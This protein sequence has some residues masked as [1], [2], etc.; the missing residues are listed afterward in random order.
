VDEA[1]AEGLQRVS[2]Q[3]SVLSNQMQR[4]GETIHARMLLLEGRVR[5]IENRLRAGGGAEAGSWR[6]SE[7]RPQT[8]A[9]GARPGA[10]PVDP[11]R[12]TTSRAVA[13]PSAERFTDYIVPPATN[14]GEMLEGV[15]S[16]PI[17]DDAEE[18]VKNPARSWSQAAAESDSLFAD[19]EA[20]SQVVVDSGLPAWAT[21]VQ[22][23]F[24]ETRQT[25]RD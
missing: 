13:R 1:V 4:M 24:E 17:H 15:C 10:E 12:P 6:P 18:E 19:A 11:S 20:T 16:I 2:E 7:P 23:S 25:L 21:E 5:T 22:R 14:D 3:V 9:A 8:S